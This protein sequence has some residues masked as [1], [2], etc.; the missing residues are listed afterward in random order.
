MTQTIG[1]NDITILPSFTTGQLAVITAELL[2][3]ATDLP[4]PRYFS[5]SRG[6]QQVSLQFADD[7]G[8][9]TALRKWADRFHT[10]VIGRNRTRDDDGEAYVYCTVRFIYHGVTFEAYASITTG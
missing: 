3:E 8:T 1:S 5:V 10:D 4:A 7:P 6:S 2:E 9:Y